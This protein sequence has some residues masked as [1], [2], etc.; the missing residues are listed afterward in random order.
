[1]R[2]VF[3]MKTKLIALFVLLT[4][5]AH[6]QEA[7]KREDNQP[8]V[9]QPSLRKELLAM[10]K[11]DQKVRTAVV[12]ELTEKGASMLDNKPIT[13]PAVLK[14]V[15][16]TSRKMATV[17]KKNRTRLKAIL[18]KY[19]WPGKTLVGKDGA[20]AAWLL[21]QHADLDLAFQKKCLKLMKAAPRGEV[22]PQD[23]AYLTDRVLVGEKKKQKYGTQF[24]AHKGV[25][26]PRPIEDVANVDK[27]RAE[28][29]L[30][31]LAEYLKTARA[32]Y[33]KLEG[34]QPKKKAKN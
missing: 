8:A 30:P 3:L 5:S 1:L 9:K 6:A 18:A 11:E 34:K 10:M 19:G 13:D 16:E 17:D 32:N 33:E 21:V 23:V 20:H 15:Q 29:G 12:K 2:K 22:E 4:S 7:K 27:R 14:V 26:K 28:V 31:P 24:E 25:L